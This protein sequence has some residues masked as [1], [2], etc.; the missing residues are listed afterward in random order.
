ML[1]LHRRNPPNA[2]QWDGVGGKLEPGEDPYTACRR[3]VKEETGL[4]VPAPQLRTLL[5]IA[6]RSTGHLWVLFVFTAD[7]PGGMPVASEE[8]ELA[9]VALDR[10]HTLPVIPDL[11]I[12]LPHVL[13]APEVL[14][15]RSDLDTEDTDSMRRVEI[16]GPP[17]HAAVIYK[18]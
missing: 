14:V 9:W 4:D 16:V 11:P 18:R 5:V 2:G 15:I 13:S 17:S 3:E 1:L 6:V 12:I 7:S 8:G 10:I